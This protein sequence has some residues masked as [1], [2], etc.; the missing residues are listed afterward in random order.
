MKEKRVKEIVIETSRRLVIRRQGASLLNWC[1]ECDAVAGWV[2]PD[3]ATALTG[4]N[5]M[6]LYR[7][8]ESKL[9]HGL[10][11]RE[12]FLLI[13]LNSLLAGKGE[14]ATPETTMEFRDQMIPTAGGASADSSQLK[15]LLPWPGGQP[16]FDESK[17]GCRIAPDQDAPRRRRPG[18]ELNHEA[19]ANML[20]RLDADEERA[21]E[22]Y[23]KICD[24]LT[25]FF[26][27]RGGA[28]PSDLTDETVNRVARRL[29]EGDEIRADEPILYFYGVA[30]NVLRERVYRSAATFLSLDD[31]LPSE[32][33]SE[34]PHRLLDELNARQGR[35]R[36]L[37][38]LSRCLDELPAQSR[39]LLLGYYSDEKQARVERRKQMADSLGITINA[40]KIRVFRIRRTLERRMRQCMELDSLELLN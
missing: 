24:R 31:L 36:L 10:E 21:A 11:S 2:T 25:K 6:A 1:V 4:I 30:R 13:C 16:G 23:S 3:E 27:C 9:L 28:S 33:P 5:S 35:E 26:E 40:L 20:A 37:E 32:H 19:F 14:A 8:V 18:W 7:R 12:G 15:S 22:K 39:E 17:P 38:C 29:Q 34:D